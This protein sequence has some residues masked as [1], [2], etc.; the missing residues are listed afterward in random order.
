[1]PYQIKKQGDKF[2]VKKKDGSKTFGKHDSHAKALKQL[3]AL[4]MAERQQSQQGPSAGPMN[5]MGGPSA[6]PSN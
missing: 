6:I 2:H 1:M 3:A 5:P 4:M